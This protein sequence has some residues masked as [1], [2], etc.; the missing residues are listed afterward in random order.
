MPFVQ[1]LPTIVLPG[2]NPAPPLQRRAGAPPLPVRPPRLWDLEVCTQQQQDAISL[3]IDTIRAIHVDTIRNRGG[4]WVTLANNMGARSVANIT[5][6]C[7]VC[8]GP[9]NPFASSSFSSQSLQ[10]CAGFTSRLWLE[11]LIVTQLVK[12]SGG[13]DLDAYSVKNFLFRIDKASFPWAYYPI[14]ASEKALMCAAGVRQNPPWA[15]LAGQYTLWDNV[16][17]KLWPINRSTGAILPHG[18][19]LIAAGIPYWQ[20]PC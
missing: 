3:A 18:S 17:G 19:S 6:S 16:G 15:F 7:N 9:G 2:V 10:I 8:Q 4:E 12:L 13:N 20:H 5:I 1:P 11:E 14:L